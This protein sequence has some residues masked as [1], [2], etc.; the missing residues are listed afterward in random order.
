VTA[1]GA[2]ASDPVARFAETAERYC[3]WS[4][5]PPEVVEW[6]VETAIRFLLELTARALDLPGVYVE[7]DWGVDLEGRTHEEW[8]AVF[9]R[10]VTIPVQYY[11]T[12]D[13]EELVDGEAL[14]GDVHD[15]LADTWRDVRNA[16]DYYRAG[17]V[18]EAHWHWRWTLRNHWG[19]HATEALRVLFTL[20]PRY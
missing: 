12:R 3:A 1:A 18:D 11:G 2:G 20:V 6:E 19:A 13:P 17:R 9:R 10:F 16:L 14:V 4:E 15:D 5:N 7:D 8:Q